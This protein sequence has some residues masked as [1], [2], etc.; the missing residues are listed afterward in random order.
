MAPIYEEDVP[1]YAHV[2]ETPM[3]ALMEAAVG[4]E[5]ETSSI[6]MLA[7]REAIVDAIDALSERDQWIFNALFIEPGE[8]VTSPQGFSPSDTGHKSLRQVAA[9]LGL[10]KTQ[11]AR[12]RDRILEEL[13]AALIDNPAVQAHLKR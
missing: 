10:S 8:R 12:E 7:L 6:E 4:A 5:P 2:P 9:E 13:Q 1:L 3:Q 11:I